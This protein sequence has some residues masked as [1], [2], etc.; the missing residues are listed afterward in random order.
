VSPRLR[1]DWPLVDDIAITEEILFHAQWDAPETRVEGTSPVWLARMGA[2]AFRRGHHAEALRLWTRIPETSDLAPTVRKWR[3]LA[4]VHGLAGSEENA[5]GE[6]LASALA[7][8]PES[9]HLAGEILCALGRFDEGLARLEAGR[10][11]N[12]LVEWRTLRGAIWL[13]RAGR[14]RE[15][16]ELLDARLEKIARLEV[17]LRVEA[18]CAWLAA[19]LPERAKPHEKALRMALPGL[20]RLMDGGPEIGPLPGGLEA[21]ADDPRLVALGVWF[22]DRTSAD[23]A[24]QALDKGPSAPS[25]VLPG[26]A[27]W[28]A[29]GD[30]AAYVVVA[31]ALTRDPRTAYVGPARARLLVH[32]DR[33]S[34]IALCLS[35]NI[36]AFLWPEASADVEGIAMLL[37]PYRRTLHV[38][39][40]RLCDLP[41][42]IR[43]YVGRTEVPSPYTGELEEM[44]FH[45]FS[46]VAVMS[47]FLESYGWGSEHRED[48]HRGF[49]DRGRLDGM[50]AHRQ[51]AAMDPQRVPSESYR[52]MHSRSIITLEQTRMGF[53]IEAKFRPSP[54]PDAVRALNARFETSFP[55]DLPLDCVGVLMHFAGSLT[56]EELVRSIDPGLPQEEWWRLHAAGALLHGSFALDTW[57]AGLPVIFADEAHSIA[58][59]YGRLGFLLQRSIAAPALHEHI[60]TGPFLSGLLPPESEEYEDDEDYE[61]EEIP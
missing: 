13:V 21:L 6:I 17:E 48:P 52:T 33:P 53:V 30:S 58:W 4:L 49:V 59:T 23:K 36:P 28:Q 40:P 1:R 11:E 14:T 7:F 5:R 32:P 61:E 60:Q 22:L 18:I 8:A 10:R 47:P 44:D 35:P 3:A 19:G 16:G 38:D 9:S 34:R 27:M 51:T 37:A 41:R 42:S 2:V 15:A 43:L 25:G 57:L 29:L 39:E 46:R 56:A 20:A 24:H 50:L 12:E 45:T 54:H 55:E 31:E 26:P